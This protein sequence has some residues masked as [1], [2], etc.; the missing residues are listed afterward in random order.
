VL[1]VACDT[2]PVCREVTDWLARQCKVEPITVGWDLRRQ[3]NCNAEWTP[4]R[5]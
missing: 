5:H 4:R 1:M 2:L 3:S